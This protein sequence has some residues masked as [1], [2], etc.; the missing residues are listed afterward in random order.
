[1]SK[2]GLQREKCNAEVL[3]GVFNQ[4]LGVLMQLIKLNSLIEPF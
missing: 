3:L 4:G 2:M 1:M